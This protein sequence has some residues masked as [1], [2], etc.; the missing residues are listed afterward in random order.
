MP[1][2]GASVVL[3]ALDFVRLLARNPTSLEHPSEAADVPADRAALSKA[4]EELVAASKQVP[5]LS[6]SVALPPPPPP[7]GGAAS[8]AAAAPARAA[9]APPPPAPPAADETSRKRRRD[10]DGTQALA[11]VDEADV[12]QMKRC[13]GKIARAL[14]CGPP[15]GQS[16]L[17]VFERRVRQ[18]ATSGSLLPRAPSISK[19]ARASKM[20]GR[21][22]PTQFLEVGTRAARAEATRGGGRSSKKQR[23]LKLALAADASPAAQAEAAAAAASGAPPTTSDMRGRIPEM[24]EPYLTLVRRMFYRSV[25]RALPARACDWARAQRRRRVHPSR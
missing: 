13:V 23:V 18:G 1:T 4:A 12:T 2:G 14:Y 8:G 7:A 22:S 17:A 21:A 6:L 10:S 9:A 11:D 3:Q 5:P 19:H 25:V 15:I 16:D 24:W 20:G